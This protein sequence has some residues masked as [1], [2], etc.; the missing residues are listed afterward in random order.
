MQSSMAKRHRSVSKTYLIHVHSILSVTLSILFLGLRAYLRLAHQGSMHRLALTARTVV[1]N[2]V[3][4]Q[5]AVDA[6]MF[7]ADRTFIAT[8][9]RRNPVT[10]FVDFRLFLFCWDFRKRFQA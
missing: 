5:V 2:L 7:L 8:A 3:R 10:V 4:K 6:E 9:R 1:Y